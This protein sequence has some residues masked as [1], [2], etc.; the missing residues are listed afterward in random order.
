[1]SDMSFSEAAELKHFILKKFDV[2][3]HIHDVCGGMYLSIDQPHEAV[4][5]FMILYC[6]EKGY[7]INVSEDG[8]QFYIGS[9][10]L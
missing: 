6:K 3:L 7:G 4:K 1:M 9:A 8:T 10:Y 2:V 5:E